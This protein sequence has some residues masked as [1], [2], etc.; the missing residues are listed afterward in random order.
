MQTRSFQVICT[1]SGS[2]HFK[3]GYTY[4]IC[5]GAVV[6]E[7]GIVWCT[8]QAHSGAQ[9][10]NRVFENKSWGATF[11]EVANSEN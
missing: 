7:R 9:A 8:L 5:D 1:K 4:T 10:L 3:E 6:D 2:D 11:K